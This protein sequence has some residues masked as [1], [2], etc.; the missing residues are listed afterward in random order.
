M[1]TRNERSNSGEWERIRYWCDRARH[2]TGLQLRLAHDIRV[3]ADPSSTAT[4]ADD[5]PDPELPS[6]A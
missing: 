6:A 2:M 3:L 4:P 1:M 5:E